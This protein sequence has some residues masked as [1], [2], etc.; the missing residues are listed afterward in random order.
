MTG[1]DGTFKRA[2]FLRASEYLGVR[3]QTVRNWFIPT[4]YG[5]LWRPGAATLARIEELLR[6]PEVTF[7][8]KK[9]G[10]KRDDVKKITEVNGVF[11]K[12]L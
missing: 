2:A 11:V 7:E 12:N 1:R 4:K 8:R 9:S 6:Q 10:P 5:E 3:R